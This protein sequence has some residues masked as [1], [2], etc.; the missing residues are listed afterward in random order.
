MRGLSVLEFALN[1]CFLPFRTD[2]FGDSL[3]FVSKRRGENEEKSISP[4]PFLHK[5]WFQGSR[6]HLRSGQV[7]AQRGGAGGGQDH[8]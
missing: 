5:I 3:L 8:V 1:T 7:P 2:F 6:H 4:F